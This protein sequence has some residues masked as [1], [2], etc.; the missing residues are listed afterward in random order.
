MA[1]PSVNQGAMSLQELLF[2][3]LSLEHQ[4]LVK[5]VLGC[6]KHPAQKELCHMLLAFL[7]CGGANASGNPFINATY[8][9]LAKKIQPQMLNY[10]GTREN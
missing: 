4:K 7:T 5:P 1:Q 10:H 9:Y 3:Q 6:L 2:S 8:L